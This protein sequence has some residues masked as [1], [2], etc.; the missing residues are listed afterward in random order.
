MGISVV[1]CYITDFAATQVKYKKIIC[2]K[3]SADDFFKTL[4]IPTE[5]QSRA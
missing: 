3:L 5:H 2:R 4:I 1:Y